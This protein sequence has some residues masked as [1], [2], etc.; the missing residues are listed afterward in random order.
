MKNEII[1]DIKKFNWNK[2][3]EIGNSLS[4]L[5]GRQWRF[6][7]ATFIEKAIEKYGVKGLKYVAE[8]HRDHIWPIH[9]IDVEVKSVLSSS[10]YLK[11]GKLKK[12]YNIR[13]NN[14]M[15]TNKKN[16]PSSN[17]VA[18][19][20][21]CVYNDGAFIVDGK[22]SIDSMTSNGDGFTLKISRDDV[23]EITGKISSKKKNFNFK[24]KVL[25]KI[26]EII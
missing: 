23:I 7:K 3:I 9:K 4:D 8:D 18:N 14:S 10:M 2:I 12:N 19:V 6:L 26:E 21:I 11:N 24:S 16:V 20:I 22:N 17:H 5:N 25:E 15:G 13:F 1:S